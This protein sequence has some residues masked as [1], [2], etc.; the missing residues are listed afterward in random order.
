M[1]SD[2]KKLIRQIEEQGCEVRKARRGGHHKVYRDGKLV[3]CF[4]TTTVSRRGLLNQRATLR[5][6]GLKV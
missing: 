6:L 2:W 4:P 1:D 5:K 3:S